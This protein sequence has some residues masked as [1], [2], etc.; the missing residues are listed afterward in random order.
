METIIQQFWAILR[1]IFRY[2]WIT[3]LTAWG[4][5][6]I[7][8][9]VVLM[10]PNKYEARARVFVDPSTALHPVIQGLA[11]EQDINAQL[12][13]VRQSLLSTPNLEK[14]IDRAGLAPRD[15][16]PASRAKAAFDLSQRIDITAVPT[17]STPGE[18][19]VPSKTY[20]I[21]YQDSTRARSLR[22][23]QIL[24]EAF[25]EGTLGGKRRDSE[26]AQRFIEGQIKEYEAKL[27]QA[28]Q[29]LAEFKK[30]NAGMVPGDQPGDYFT[31]L[32]A[33]VDA[34]K[35]SETD[36]N[37][38]LTKRA[39]LATQ[40]RGEGPEAASTLSTVGGGG[41]N[42]RGGDTLSRIQETQAKLDD[43]LLR[44]T[45]KHP[46]VIALRETLQ[47]LKARRAA[48]LEALKRGD[49]GAAVATGASAN[50]VYQSIQLQL[51]QADVEIA[52]LRSELS[53]HRAKVADL[54]RMVDTMPQVEAEYA[55]LNRDYAVNKAQYNALVERLE[56]ARLGGEA[57]ATGSVRFDVIDPP[58]ADYNPVS[59]KRS[60]LLATV[61]LL[62][63]A[64]GAGI[65]Y[66]ITMIKPVFH[67]S[68][69]L[70]ALTGLPVLGVV[71]ASHTGD[72]AASMRREYLVYSVACSTFL[73]AL[74]A[75]VFVG[76]TYAPL[77]ISLG[78]H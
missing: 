33:E 20:V 47:E 15:Q 23:V 5:C 29:T 24:L 4:V 76:R 30:H 36:L 70:A 45:D 65:A 38:A 72:K 1:D 19:P 59:P 21:S 48:E 32:Q 40:L 73:L 2:R 39:A 50:P 63:L 75:V 55:R 54:K 68:K 43:M 22:V 7:A 60:M 58:S 62:A 6:L 61:L 37:I 28:E 44:F 57:D 27:S 10:L 16:D 35:K 69:Q 9:P 17:A 53:D 56:K 71:S 12:S 51:N 42:A 46:D 31:R 67:T 52:A 25:M 11:I 18:P 14:I 74:I 64:A 49:A 66:V 41:P 26:A 34:V 77:S 3:F 13:L 8:W 78:T